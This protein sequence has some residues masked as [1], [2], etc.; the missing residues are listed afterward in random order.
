MKDISVKTLCL[1]GLIKKQLIIPFSQWKFLVT[2]SSNFST[3]YCFNIQNLNPESFK[4]AK[5]LKLK[6]HQ[7]LK[8]AVT[9]IQ[10]K[11]Q[12]KSLFVWF[13]AIHF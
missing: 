11:K 2:F 4:T 13:L 10:S 7:N 5:T 6:M 8:L 9:D 1:I 12:G 3:L